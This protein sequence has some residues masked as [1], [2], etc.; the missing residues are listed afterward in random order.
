MPLPWN[1]IR[2][3]ANAFSLNWKSATNERAESQTFWNE[4]FGVFGITRRRMASFE[5]PVKKLNG[6]YG[7]ID[8][9][10]K[11]ELLVEH[12]SKGK[13]LNKAYSQ[14]LDYFSNLKEYEL[15]KYILV[16]DF[17]QFKL[18]DLDDDQIYEFE[19]AE[20]YENVHL[21]GF[22]AGYEK[23][24]QRDAIPVN[25]EAANKMV[26]LYEALVE[27]GFTGHE[28]EIFLM[29]LLF[30]LFAD[31]TGLFEKKI[32]ADFIAAQTEENGNDLGEK[33]AS[34][35]QT[36]SKPVL[37]RQKSISDLLN[38]FPYING[39]LF[40]EKLDTIHFTK[41]M[42]ELLLECS[43]FNWSSISPAIFGSMFQ[44]TMDPVK[45]SNLGAYYTSEENIL[46]LIRP[47]FLDSLWKELD[48]ITL[49][50]SGKANSLKLFQ[51]KLSQLIFLDPACGCGNFLIVTY[52]ELRLLELKLLS[53]WKKIKGQDNELKSIIS[54]NQFY[55]IEKEEF[56]ARIAETALWL[57]EHQMNNE[58]SKQCNIHRYTLPLSESKT[59]KIH[60]AFNIDWEALV[61]KA[62][63]NYI[64]GNPQFKG[65][66]NQSKEQKNEIKSLF[67]NKVG[68]GDLDYVSAWFL[69]AS[70]YIQGTN[71]EVAF[72]A[73]N[74]VTMGVQVSPLWDCLISK[75][76]IKINF[77]H[78][79]FK[80]SSEAKNKAA[81]HVVIIGFANF[82]RKQKE[83]FYY[84]D[85][86]G[87]PERK[88]VRKI[89]PYLMEG[90]IILV[91]KRSTPISK[92][93]KI[94][95]GNQP[96]DKGHLLL[97]DKEKELILLN[98]PPSIAK[99]IKRVMGT[100]ELLHN[101]NLWCLWLVDASPAELKSFKAISQRLI[102]VKEYRLRSTDQ[103]TVK[104]AAT[105]YLFREQNNPDVYLA[106]PTT[107]SE[108]RNFITAEFLDC[109]T[110]PTN[111]LFIIPDAELWHFGILSSYMN[112][113][114]TENICGRTD[115]RNRYSK[116]IGYNTFP[117]PQIHAT[118]KANVEEASKNILA[119]RKLLTD[120]TLAEM[121][122]PICMPKQL[123][124]AHLRLDK[125]VE[126][127]YQAK[128]FDSDT[129]RLEHLLTLYNQYKNNTI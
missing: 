29:R 42:R 45:R 65:A 107:T 50:K 80:W 41:S 70:E 116:N 81:V 51:L 20:L 122:D 125:A 82:E 24:K 32:F 98:S 21:L 103:A 6:K 31:D 64:I 115:N 111:N 2:E 49:E 92:V 26:K 91:S 114:W 78:R 72:V 93:P 8:L 48:T 89:T 127:C 106:I 73:T 129:E 99:Y 56:P 28:L 108:K 95:K 17:N 118:D 76:N 69:K 83:L 68:S 101:L 44:L 63:L 37:N 54:I 14:A 121:Y 85:P 11:G 33:L 74:S 3:N 47:L 39:T 57:T 58:L 19:L 59:I 105:P 25:I 128:P 61:K 90:E 86:S 7:F 75:Y 84:K 5:E 1:V 12:K 38:E 46:K 60:N 53:E 102:K 30:C 36:L 43:Y 16:S 104:K 23:K 110:I 109:N 34:I 27:E 4:F 52:R 55:G 40:R 79:T 9:F 120:S 112:R 15:P 22:I 62:K 100:N 13:D 113:V 67:S 94:R 124:D 126:K 35:F 123:A 96:T 10:W 88:L 66:N 97:N 77:A 71:I 117:W 119:V 87:E 18:Y